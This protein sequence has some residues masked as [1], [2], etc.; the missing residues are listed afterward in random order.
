MKKFYAQITKLQNRIDSFDDAAEMRRMNG[1]PDDETVATMQ[2]APRDALAR[3]TGEWEAYAAKHPARAEAIIARHE[4][5]RLR[6]A[7]P[8][9]PPTAP[10]APTADADALRAKAAALRADAAAI[11]FLRRRLAALKRADRLADRADRADRSHARYR[12]ACAERRDAEASRA[13]LLPRIAELE[14]K[15]P[16]LPATRK[17]RPQPP[18]PSDDAL[19][20]AFEYD[21][22]AGA[23]SRT[24]TGSPVN[25]Y[26]QRIMFAGAWVQLP[27]LIAALAHFTLRPGERL[28][29]LRPDADDRWA[30]R[31][32]YVQS[33]AR[34]NALGNARCY[35]V[36]AGRSPD[37]L[38]PED[39]I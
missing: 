38:R 13:M 27:T 22:E 33:Q 6:R 39:F 34:A 26:G 18:A 25:V 35:A 37:D 21:A 20:A 32:L 30:R 29:S 4:I 28:R 15:L 9:I 11:P 14:T 1:E 16:A 7:L 2:L 31:N 8:V 10:T 19:R 17:P 24:T 23:V 36:A 3:L 5:D 12:V